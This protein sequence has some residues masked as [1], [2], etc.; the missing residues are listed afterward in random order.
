MSPDA[1][2]DFWF[3][4]ALRDAAAA[5]ERGRVW[6]Q[7]DPAFDREVAERFG[8]GI[9]LAASGELDGWCSD[10]RS[11]LALVLLLDQFPRHAWRGSALAFASDAQALE[12][13]LAAIA[14]G[15]DVELH[16]LAC[17]FLYLPLGHAEDLGQQELSVELTQALR[18]RAPAELAEL[19]G[20]FADFARRHRDVIR[21][22]GRFPHRNAA[23]GREPRAEELRYLRAGGEDF[24]AA[25]GIELAGRSAPAREG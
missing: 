1:V 7:A 24:A 5:R 4:G 12:V 15:F 20:E 3:G 13:A 23:L 11:A 18:A 14:A 21:R 10:A 17:S 25:A 22:F 19:L 16:P 6:F 2:L 8:P 9:E